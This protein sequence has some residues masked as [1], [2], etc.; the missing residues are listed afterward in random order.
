MDQ[1]PLSIIGTDEVKRMG[2]PLKKAGELSRKYSLHVTGASCICNFFLGTGKLVLGLI[3]LS[4]FTCVSAFYTYGMVLARICALKG[5]GKTREKQLLHYRLTGMILIM[6]S[7]LY[8]FYS[9]RMLRYPE[10]PHYDKY[11]G[12]AIATFTFTEIGLS[13]RGVVIERKN[14]EPLYH[15]LKMV[16]LAASMISLVLTQTALLSF[17]HQ[18]EIGYNPSFSNGVMGLLMGGI[19]TLTGIFMLIRV[20]KMRTK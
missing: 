17:T 2:N 8:T 7:L 20:K 15:A 13:I 19:S 1:Y 18:G 10:P 6:A 16:N 5:M 4:F 11:V 3:S 12:L 14:K 9:T